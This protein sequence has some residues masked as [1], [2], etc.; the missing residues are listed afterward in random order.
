MKENEK[1]SDGNFENI[2]G[3]YRNNEKALL[4]TH[5]SSIEDNLRI[6]ITT[7]Y[8]NEK[9]FKII[10]QREPDQLEVNKIVENLSEIGYELNVNSSEIIVTGWTENL[11]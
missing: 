8:I 7:R 1:L 6:E 4:E 10:F 2:E 5:I 9:G 3:S 11:N